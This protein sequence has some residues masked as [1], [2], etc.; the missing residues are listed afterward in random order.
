MSLCSSSV[1]VR[2]DRWPAC[3]FIA[4]LYVSRGCWAMGELIFA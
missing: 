4:I 1:C 2:V 3:A